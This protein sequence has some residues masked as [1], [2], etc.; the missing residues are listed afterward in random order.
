M[1][2][3]LLLVAVALLACVPTSA[4]ASA[5]ASRIY[6]VPGAA[7]SALDEITVRQLPGGAVLIPRAGR[8]AV[9]LPGA[10][11]FDLPPGAESFVVRLS[12][13]QDDLPLLS[14]VGSIL[15]VEGGFALVAADARQVTDPRFQ[16]F[17]KERL[18][19]LPPPRTSTPLLQR[20]TPTPFARAS[21]VDPAIKAAIVDAIDIAKWTQYVRELSGDLVF[22][23]NGQ[24]RSTDNRHITKPGILLAQDYLVDRLQALGYT[25]IRQGF[26]VGATACQNIIAVKQGVV[27]PQEIIVVGGHHD[28]LSENINLRA[29][30]A[31]DDASGV[32]GVLHLAELLAPYRTER[33]VHFVFFSGEEQGIYGSQYYV[34]Q[35]AA[36]GWN[37]TNAM[38]LCEISAWQTNFA[39]IIE[40]EHSWE[41]LMS[42]FAGNVVQWSGIPYR[43]DY[44]SWG[45]D[46]VPFQQVGIP[47]F[48]AIHMDYEDYPYWE[49]IDDKW[50][51]PCPGLDRPCMDA[52]LALAILKPAAATLA[53][54]AVPIDRSTPAPPQ[55]IGPRLALR[56]NVPN[57][58]N[59]S[60]TI[61]F[62]LPLAERVRLDVYDAG[63]HLVR[64]LLDEER[65]AGQ[66]SVRWD[67]RDGRRMP[68][69]SGLYT[70]RLIAN[71]SV[72]TRTMALVR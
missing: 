47:A 10:E 52:S 2:T 71:R 48:L 49:S 19:Y 38:V 55:V 54:L 44:Y 15:R 34:S 17:P 62:E 58:F 22:W 66:G 18:T 5:G 72:L 67:G 6:W 25:V 37:V 51:Q 41:P 20:A 70:Y 24:L 27:T 26:S 31:E 12:H 7:P 65:S 63:G 29:P 35:L 40:G 28:S 14:A 53:D 33:T 3:R 45:S 8:A 4:G 23:L 61:V 9:D 46:H 60:T 16:R 21:A 42:L 13:P 32:A 1:R 64:A 36:N 43:E 68:V 56:Q 11:G 69:A 50:N 59:P 30:G 57:P 39:T